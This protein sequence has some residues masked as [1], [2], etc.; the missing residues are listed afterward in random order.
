MVSAQFM[1]YSGV[2][3]VAGQRFDCRPVEEGLACL[4]QYWLSPGKKKGPG[5]RGVTGPLW[6]H[7]TD[8]GRSSTQGSI[9][10]RVDAVCAEPNP[11]LVR[12]AGFDAMRI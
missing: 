9:V 8:G 4:W 7:P 5:D 11:P 2:V 1:S 6:E 12:Q 3:A 10:E